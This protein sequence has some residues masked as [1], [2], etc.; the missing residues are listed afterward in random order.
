MEPKKVRLCVLITSILAA[1]A[2]RPAMSQATVDQMSCAQ[3]IEYF[4]R[5]K[6]IYK[7]I[8]NGAPLPIRMGI[9]VG[10]RTNHLCR[11]RGKS[12]RGYR[13]K[14]LDNPRCVPILVC[15]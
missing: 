5:N 14:T 10:E 9:P 13:L 1:F 2:A 7:R 15:D 11:G 6:V 12:W 4:A 8:G 3:A